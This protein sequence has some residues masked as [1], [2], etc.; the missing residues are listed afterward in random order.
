MRKPSKYCSLRVGLSAREFEH[1]RKCA[2]GLGQM[3]SACIGIQCTHD[4]NEK[5]EGLRHIRD[6]LIDLPDR[7]TSA[8]RLTLS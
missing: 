4:V 1:E 3:A 7:S 5:P 6:D 8:E 2:R